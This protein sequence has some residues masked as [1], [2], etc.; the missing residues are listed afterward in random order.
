MATGM[1][2]ATLIVLLGATPGMAADAPAAT[3]EAVMARWLGTWEGTSSGSE[4]DLVPHYRR[5]V[6]TYTAEWVLGK[7]FVQGRAVDRAGKPLNVWMMTYYLGTQDY[8]MWFFASNG[9]ESTWRGLWD[10]AT[11]TMTWTCLDADP[12]TSVTDKTRFLDADKQE[13]HVVMKDKDGA[14]KAGDGTLTRKK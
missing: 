11:Q 13:W 6:G 9:R 4:L 7:K 14:E 1:I 12:G 3:P 2:V 5:F 10:D 8:R